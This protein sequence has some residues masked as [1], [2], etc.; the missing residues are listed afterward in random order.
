MKSSQFSTGY[1]MHEQRGC[2]GNVDTFNVT[3]FRKFDFRSKILRHIEVRS[4]I[5]RPD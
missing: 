4:I 5:N 2:F 1:Q 3:T